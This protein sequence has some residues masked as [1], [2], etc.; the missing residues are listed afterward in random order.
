[1]TRTWILAAAL[2][3]LATACGGG[4]DTDATTDGPASTFPT[5]WDGAVAGNKKAKGAFLAQVGHEYP[6]TGWFEA[7]TVT[8]RD[9][10]QVN[11]LDAG[12]SWPIVQIRILGHTPEGWNELEIDVALNR[13]VAGTIPIDGDSATGRVIHGPSGSTRYLLEGELVI[14]QPG[15]EPGQM[16][17]GEFNKVVLSEVQ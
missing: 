1:M 5:P 3:A 4:D 10:V 8:G 6:G 9:V 11:V 16:V 14:T 15:I 13:F 12:A 7:G 17:E 2:V